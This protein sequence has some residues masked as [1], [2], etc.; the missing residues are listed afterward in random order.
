MSESGP[1]LPT[2]AMQQS[3]QLIWGTSDVLTTQSERQALSRS[4]RGRRVARVLATTSRDDQPHPSPAMTG[5]K[6]RALLFA[7][8]QRG[9]R[10]GDPIRRRLVN[11]GCREIRPD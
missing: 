8:R 1:G 2:W 3:R 11:G 9:R 6:W 7:A 5:S 10:A 4:C